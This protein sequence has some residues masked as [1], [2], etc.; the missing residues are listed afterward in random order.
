MS[1]DWKTDPPIW[2]DNPGEVSGNTAYGFYDNDA[3]FQWEA[4]RFA[5]WAARRLGYP[6][7]NVELKDYQFY[8]CL[9]E[10]TSEYTAQVNQFLIRENLISAQGSPTGSDITQ[11]L[12]LDSGLNRVIQLAK[13]Y[14]AEFGAGGNIPWYSGSVDVVDGQQDYNLDTLWA[15]VSES[16][17]A[18]E[19]KRIFHYGTPAVSRVYDPFVETGLARQDI[20]REFGWT[21]LSTAITYTLFPVYEDLLRIQAVEFHDQVRRS[22]YSF[23][24][25]NNNLRIF[26]IPTSNFKLWFQYILTDDRTVGASGSSGTTTGIQTGVQSDYS[27]IEYNLVPYSNINDT[28]H[29]WI[30]KYALALVKEVLGTVRNKYQSVPIPDGE[31]TLDGDTLRSE[32]QSEKEELVTQLRENLEEAG[33]T[34]QME[35]KQQE[36]EYMMGMLRGV[37][38]KIYI[39]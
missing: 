18:I 31:V 22:A 16:G 29:Q 1:N 19:V 7:M 27:N 37:P 28:G 9:E 14:G 11:K 5:R 3:D 4:P 6:I 17:K 38:M 32:A 33:R 35:K 21:G 30:R 10:A 36:N 15:A 8:E 39:G 12:I 13:S 24:L 26:P 2:D 34:R 20:L 25:V 23:E